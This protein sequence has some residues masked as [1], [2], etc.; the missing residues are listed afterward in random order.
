MA[1]RYLWTMETE[2]GSKGVLMDRPSLS[3]L[4]LA[5]AQRVKECSTSNEAGRHCVFGMEKISQKR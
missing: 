4:G 1:E 3:M 5:A 2:T